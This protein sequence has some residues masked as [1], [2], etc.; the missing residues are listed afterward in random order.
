MVEEL[1]FQL[2]QVAIGTRTILSAVPTAEEWVEIYETAKKQAVVGICF[3]GVER[4]PKEQLPPPRMI[5]QWAV[6]ADRIKDE[7]A[8]LNKECV[9]VSRFFGKYGFETCILKGQSNYANYPEW[10]QGLRTPG[11]IDIWI[12]PK[13]EESL[14]DTQR[15]ALAD[16]QLT[17]SSKRPV[18]SAIEFCQRV[19]KGEYVYY[20]NL[21]FPVLQKTPVEVHYRPTFLYCMWRNRRLQKWISSF[22]LNTSDTKSPINRRSMQYNDFTIAP[23]EFNVVFQLLHLYKHIFEEGIGLRQLLDYYFV[24]NA[25]RDLPRPEILKIIKS[26]NL[27]DF[28]GAV[29]NVMREVFALE[30][31]VMLC[32]PNTKK[33]GVLLNEILI[34]GNFGKYDERYNWADVT[35]GSMDYRGADYAVTRF[36][37]N[38]RFL[39]SYPEEVLW[40]PFFRIYHM[41]WRKLKLW[42]YE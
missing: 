12:R 11:D 37:H 30:E 28:C 22:C 18:R 23:L 14:S 42:R 29:M 3:A 13:D 2:I 40:E 34:G 39:S 31:E 5:R 15:Q 33:G 25:A 38:Y 32:E 10:L 8:G 20:H 16:H 1:F 24:L 17:I 35:N 27:S 7:N 41:L 9:Q 21:D 26:L 6:K 19:K 36:K 4:L